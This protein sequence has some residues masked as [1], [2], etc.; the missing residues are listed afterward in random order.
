M[1]LKILGA[2]GAQCETASSI[3]ALA[4]GRVLVDAGTGAHNLSLAEMDGVKD[5]L[6]THSHLDHVAMLCFIA[7]CKIG[8]AGGH[9]LRVR[10]FPETADAI[11]SGLLNGRIWPDFERIKIGGV[12][13]LSFEYFRPFETIDCDGLRATPFPVEHAGIPTAGFV[14]HGAREN[15]V[16]I[17]D[18]HTLSDEV[19]EYL[20]TLPNFRKM[21]VETSFPD[22]SEEVAHASGHLTPS[23]LEKIVARLPEGLEIYYCHVKPR[24]D[25]EVAAQIQKRFGGRVLPL[26]EGTTFDI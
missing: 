17:S 20:H 4:D 3:S 6:I 5:A 1:R 7:E 14:L 21:T 16:F 12:P 24:Y 25:A 19:Y 26:R 11:R 23:L 8:G 22:G 13:L 18:V 10:C 2:G 9:G 15:F